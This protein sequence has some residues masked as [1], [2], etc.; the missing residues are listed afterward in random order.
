ME[1]IENIYNTNHIDIRAEKGSECR[2]V[3]IAQNILREDV[4]KNSVTMD[5]VADSGSTL[6]LHLFNKMDYAGVAKFDINVSV[7]DNCN[8]TISV[9]SLDGKQV[10]TTINV[11]ILGENST[12]NLPGLLL[13]SEG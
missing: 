6:E 10:D 3:V 9:V 13:H 2:K 7:Q 11:N 12:V 4:D 1:T 5:V 8:V